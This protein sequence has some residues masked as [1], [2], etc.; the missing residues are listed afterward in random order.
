MPGEWRP[1]LSSLVLPPAGP[2]L[3][4]LLGLLLATWRKAFGLLVAFVGL[5]LAWA[6][7]TNAI[8][9][10]LARSLLAPVVVVQPQQV[11]PVQAIVVLGGGV[12]PRAQEYGAAQPGP[13]TLLRLR[14]AAYLA[15]RTGK[16][17]AFTGGVGWAAVGAETVPEGTVARRLLQD[18][19]GLTPRWVDDQSRNTGESAVRMADLLRR[20]GIQRI[21]LVTDA[22][23]MERSTA[24]F[25]AAG[26][27]V[28][29]APTNFP[30]QAESPWLEWIPSAHGVDLNRQLL[31]EWLA[32]TVAGAG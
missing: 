13:H 30:Q 12:L 26:F 22:T 16:P 3:L 25:R 29:P 20:D 10:G 24:A 19:Y 15:K 4:V 11:Q 6:L 9:V 7:G 28:L 23:H 27:Y 32:R 1:L 5:L 31:R 2:L 18:E 21:A 17:V 14:Y 8:A